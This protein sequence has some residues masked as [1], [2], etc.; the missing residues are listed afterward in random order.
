MQ[1]SISENLAGR[2]EI[3]EFDEELYR[4]LIKQIVVYKDDSVRVIFP[5]NNS[6]KIATG[7]YKIRKGADMPQTAVK[8]KVSMI[9]AKPQY[10]RSIKLSEKKLRVAAYCRVSTEL[11]EQESSYEAQV[12][13]YTRKIEETDNWK[14]AEIYADDEKSATNT[15]KRDDFN[16]MIKDAL[17][18][19][20]DMIL[21]KSVSRFARN[22]VDFL[23]TIRKLKEKNVAVVFE[24]E[25]VNTL[26]GTG[27]I[28]ITILSSLAQEESRNIS[29]NTR[30][31]V[32]RRFE[33]GKMI[34]DHNKFMG[35]TKNENG[36]LVIVQEE[37]EIVRLIFRLYL[38]GYSAKKIS[39][40][41]EENGIK[42]ATG[43]DKWYDSVIFKMLRNEKYMG[44]ALLQKTYTV[45][46]MTKK[47]VINKGI[48]P[49]YY[50]EDDH[51]PIIPKELFYRVQEELAR[52]AAMNKAAVT[53]KKNQK[54]KFSSEYALTGLLLCG[55]CGQEYRRVTWSR[56]GKKKIV[57]R[58]SNRLTNG[59]KN[60]KKS[61]TLEE[62]AV[63]RA[64]MEAINRITRGDGDFVG[65]FRQNVIRVIGSYGGEQEPDEYD[66]KIKE[67]EEEMVDLIAE[68]ARVGS[69]TDEFD[70]RYR[71]IAEE[72]T[73]LKKEQIEDRRKKKLADSYEQRLK[74]MDSFLEKQT[75]QIPEFDNDLVRRLIASI[76]VVSAEKLIIQFQSG[77]VM[78]QEIRYE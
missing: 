51:E 2:E 32:V 29:E 27:E 15:K 54:S 1:L 44:D 7:I 38:E 52:R 20:I 5:N 60:C 46:F 13:Y 17:D 30:W 45:D 65:A 55:D 71:R 10:D 69:Y 18:G 77:I 21:T 11:E 50:V 57:W 31:G 28:L 23:L 19:K 16:A 36:D 42:T 63:N 3:A 41:L 25:G 12:E 78:E 47:K 43:Q 14:M 73:T 64:V 39:Q 22:T 68:N 33:N 56:N 67:K 75:C 6:I 76:K 59:T 62:G 72:I 58:C 8:K 35:Y 34:V 9:P 24:K 48:V 70:E 40:Y 61:E 53:R 49:Q 37:A 66:E 4:K 74:N 26:D